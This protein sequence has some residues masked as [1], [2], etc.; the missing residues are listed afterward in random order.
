MKR[1]FFLLIIGL[2]SVIPA[3]AEDTAATA[4]APAPA[5]EVTPAPPAEVT[6][7]VVPVPAA[8]EV[9]PEAPAVAP[10]VENT[11]PGEAVNTENLEFV[12]GEVSALDEA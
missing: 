10:A 4:P 6:A 7:P 9:K 1:T 5:A 12:S 3:M 2:I 8:E 11:A